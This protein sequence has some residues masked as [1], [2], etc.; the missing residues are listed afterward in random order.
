[1]I[2]TFVVGCTAEPTDAASAAATTVAAILADQIV[3]E[4]EYQSAIESQRSCLRVAGFETSVPKRDKQGI[5]WT[6][7]VKATE[8]QQEAAS[9]AM[10]ACY[11]KTLDGVERTFFIANL[12][13]GAKRDAE[14]ARLIEC[15]A[16]AGVNGISPNMTESQIVKQ[17]AVQRADDMSEGLWC[18]EDH[19]ALFPEGR[20]PK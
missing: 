19:S 6:Y 15:L 18:I 11:A 12:P 7:S 16:E 10:D 4:A 17:V 9:A 13:T 14:F 8:A 5:L 1:M 2:S 20:F 3:T